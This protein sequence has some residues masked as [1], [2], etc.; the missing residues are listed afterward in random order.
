MT[1]MKTQM[2]MKAMAETGRSQH[3]ATE[4]LNR[5]MAEAYAMAFCRPLASA[6]CMRSTCLSAQNNSRNGRLSE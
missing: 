5:I 6:M 1:F 4:M 2:A 3:K